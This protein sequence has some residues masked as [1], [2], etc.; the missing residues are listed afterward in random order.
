MTLKEIAFDAKTDKAR[1]ASRWPALAVLK[2]ETDAAGKA[3]PEGRLVVIGD[4]DFATN[5][6]FDAVRQRQPLPQRRQ[7]ADRGSRPHLHPAQDPE[8][9]GRSS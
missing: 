5:R 6:Y 3:G 8:S 7:L 4:S 9:R 1:P 2:A